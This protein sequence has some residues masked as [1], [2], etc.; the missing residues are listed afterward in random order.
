MALS[1]PNDLNH[2]PGDFE[3]AFRVIKVD[4]NTWVGAH[5][6][7]LPIAGARGVYGGHTCAQTLLVAM[8]SAPGFIPHSFHSHFIKAGSHKIPYTFKVTRLHDGRNFCMREIKVIQKD[9]IIYTA[10]SS[11]IKKGKTV[12]S[13]DLNIMHPPPPLFR[14]YPDPSELRVITHTDFV[15]NAFSKEFEDYTLCPEEDN[16]RAAERWITVW[17]G[18][19]QP[20]KSNMVDPKYNY[21]GLADLSDSALLTTLARVL[22]LHWNPTVENPYESFDEDKDARNIMNVTLNALHIFHYNAMSLDHH[23][24]FHSDDFNAFNIVKDWLTLTYQF[25]ILRNNRALVRGYFYNKEG[26]CVATVIQEGLTYMRP[27][28]PNKHRI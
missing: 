3:E 8:E 17:S 4:E 20:K 12:T 9:V 15:R 13:G 22:H 6:L 19:Q 10:L 28:V 27:G 23:L 5:P 21:V 25:K 7:R 18:L 26:N 11:L 16:L 2:D 14:K 1:P 24:Y